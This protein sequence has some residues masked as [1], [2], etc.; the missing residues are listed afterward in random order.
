MLTGRVTDASGVQPVVSA[1]VIVSG[2]QLIAL[3]DADGVYRF[4]RVP[5][6]V[7]EVGVERLGYLPLTRL[8]AVGSGETVTADF[9]IAVSAVAPDAVVATATGPRRRREL[10]NSAATVEVSQELETSTPLTFPDL[11]QGKAP[12]VQV[13]QSSG[14]VGTSSTIKIRGNSSISL[15]NTPLIYVDGSRISNDIRSGPGVGGQNASRLNDLNP[16]D[17]ETIEI[18]KGPSAAT[19]YGTEAAAGVIRITTRRGRTGPAE[20]TYRA[21][22]GAN[23]DA[24]AWPDNAVDLRSPFLLG[25]A[26]RDTVYTTNLLQ[27]LGTDQNPW[28]TGLEQGYGVSLRGGAEDVT[29]FVS[30]E[31]G[32]RE[33]SLP[34][35]HA[36]HRTLRANLNLVPSDN[37]DVAISTGFG[38][39]HLSLPNNDNTTLG[40]LGVAL[41]GSP[42]ELP[43]VRTD[44]VTGEP[45]VETCAIDFE[46]A[47]GFGVPLGSFGCRGDAFFSGR[48]FEDVATISNTQKIERF[49][50]SAAVNYRPMESITAQG[51]IG[52][53]QFSD[54]TGTFIPV[55]P[56]LVFGSLSEGFRQLHHFVSRNVTV[57]GNVAGSFRLSP[58][59][60]STTAL[61]GQF[62]GEKLESS[63]S[64]GRTLPAGTST[65]SNAVTTEGFEGVTETRTLGVFL[66]QQLAFWDRLF[67]TPAV[68]LDENS[69]FG[70]NLGRQA[71][72]RVMASWVVSEELWFPS[73]WLQ[74]VRVRAAWGE[75]GKQPT[76]F[77]ALQLLEAERVAFRGQDVAGVA[78]LQPGNPS[79][80]PERGQELELGFDAEL[81]GG[82]VAVD[83]T[84][85]DQVTKDAIVARRVAPST[86]FPD[87]V[88]EN[89]GRVENS[90]VKLGITGVAVNRPDL[91]WT[92]QLVGATRKGEVTKLDEPIVFGLN[93]NTQ[94][95]QRAYPF[96]AY[97]GRRYSI[98]SSGSVESTAR[99][100]FLGHPTPEWE[101]SFLTTVR[102]FNRVTL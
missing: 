37:T 48:T 99:P 59:V 20:W 44:P 16:F 2:T 18:V 85:Y 29:Y 49:T 7:V 6:G 13:A 78:V 45:D 81:L 1:E 65:V 87:A 21:S 67:L 101:G 68:R 25:A 47:L 34:N 102:L 30:G 82:L 80:K 98:G 52:Y 89:I 17:I 83:F 77:A 8:I 76:S 58:T 36:D 60:T 22:L 55:D 50:G 24:T 27:G 32:D 12:G 26:A 57:E 61:G 40:Y 19:L 66:E 41:S 79:L 53:D 75:S 93:G 31:L 23:W 35:N 88:F 4:P 70:M 10:G 91:F 71:Y 3:T 46:A 54:Q 43:L 97:F 72:P 14:T 42:W 90:G 84:W 74:S 92:V 33:G 86:G 63:S 64:V 69:A 51:T 95:H 11:I 38:S 5:A 100:V 62:F 9:S 15:D 39:T 28:R 94:R 56:S 96:G 73:S